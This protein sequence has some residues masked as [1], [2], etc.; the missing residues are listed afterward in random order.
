MIRPAL[1]L[2][3]AAAAVAS[4]A[5]TSAAAHAPTTPRE[6]GV[7]IDWPTKQTRV[8]LAPGA[9]VRVN[10]RSL[11]RGSRPV[12]VTLERTDTR[13]AR[14]VKRRTLRRGSF[15][16][17]LPRTAAAR[18]LLSAA[19]GR[20]TL[21]RLRIVTP[22]RRSG[23][24]PLPQPQPQSPTQPQLP[25]I[26]P[27]VEPREGRAALTGDRTTMTI[28]ET[29]RFTYANVG[30]TCLQGGYGYGVERLG[31]DRWRSDG[32]PQV[33]PAIALQLRPGESFS[34]T[35][36]V[37]DA[38]AHPPGHYR[39]S[40]S[41]TAPGGAGV[42]VPATWEFNVLPAGPLPS[43]DRCGAP[44]REARVSVSLSR[45]TITPQEPLE[46]TVTNDGPVCLSGDDARVNAYKETENGFLRVPLVDLGTPYGTVRYEPGDV[47]RFSFRGTDGREALTPGHYVVGYPV[48]VPP[49]DADTIVSLAAE[50]EFDVVTEGS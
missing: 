28:G 34:Q 26:C 47:R 3:L 20:R 12:T 35:F 29:L 36:R 39:I 27:Q 1:L 23:R 19:V 50:A 33:V 21:R 11:R 7:R 42:R 17:R 31:S 16:A 37:D 44:D 45:S 24:T 8:T 9:T 6:A 41:W 40:E 32:V 43:P 25:P 13:R 48:W 30:P 46:L 15:V 22:A 38:T 18:Y 14:V 4:S 49:A 2:S 5:A 10:I